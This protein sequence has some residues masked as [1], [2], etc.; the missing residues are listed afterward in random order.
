MS[1]PSRG[2]PD[3]EPDGSRSAA[4]PGGIDTDTV[5]SIRRQSVR[6]VTAVL[7]RGIGVRSL[8]LLGTIVLARLLLPSDFGLLAFGLT[9]TAVGGFLTDAGLAAG[10]IRGPR[11]PTREQLRAILGIQLTLTAIIIG[12]AS[13][14]LWQRGLEGRVTVVMMLS[15]VPGTFRVPASVQLERK[16]AFG[17]VAMAE[18]VETVVYTALSIGLVFAGLGVWGV[19]IAVLARPLAGVVLLQR[20]AEMTVLRPG[21]HWREIL[22]VLSFGLTLQAGH[23]SVLIREQGVNLATVA[24]ADTATLGMWALSQR[25]M[26]LPFLLFESLW[27]VSF[28]A[29]SRLMEAGHDVRDDLGRALRIGGFLT[30]IAVVP[31]TAC[32]PVLVPRVFG[33]VWLPMLPVVPLAA[34]GLV[35]AGPLSAVGVGYLSAVGDARIVALANA[36]TLVP[37]A[38]AIPLLLPRIGVT[39]HGVG[40]ALACLVDALILGVALQRRAG[41]GVVRMLGPGALCAYVVGGASY[42]LV[43]RQEPTLWVGAGAALGSVAAFLAV[44]TVLAPTTVADVVRLSR[45]LLPTLRRSR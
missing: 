44:A 45:R 26:L 30:G 4:P 42:A 2:A 41:V 6:G 38:I 43:V 13:L 15:L 25:I 31:L 33:E 35:L 5:A 7:L 37:W 32:A 22:P 12:V 34:A 24:I 27:R 18:I 3:T 20:A 10:F 39:A 36:A 23:V 28:P 17:V 21:R 8:G 40:W 11:P 1:Q 16:L 19:A 9:L 29:I 14:L